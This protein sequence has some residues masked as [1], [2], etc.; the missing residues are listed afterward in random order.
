MEMVYPRTVVFVCLHGVAKSVI[1]SAYLNRLSEGVGSMS[2]RPQRGSNRS[3]T[4]H[5]KC[6]RAFYRRVLTLRASVLGG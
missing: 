2:V 1:A 3:P 6:E 4:Y 5:T